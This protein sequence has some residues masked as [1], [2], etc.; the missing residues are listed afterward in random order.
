MPKTLNDEYKTR[1]NKLKKIRE[2]G[3]NPYPEK[4]EKLQQN[5]G[6]RYG[7]LHLRIRGRYSQT[8]KDNL[9]PD[10][11]PVNGFRGQRFRHGTHRPF[12]TS[13][14]GRT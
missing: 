3:I 7:R 10:G 2:L 13:H 11:C 14:D 12:F 4:F 8:R 5:H 1:L 6:Y 9:C